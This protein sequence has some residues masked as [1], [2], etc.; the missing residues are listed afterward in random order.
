[1]IFLNSGRVC[2]SGVWRIGHRTIRA[3]HRGIVVIITIAGNKRGFIVAYF[4]L[5][6]QIISHFTKLARIFIE[7]SVKQYKGIGREFAFSTF[8]IDF[9]LVVVFLAFAVN[10]FKTSRLPFSSTAITRLTITRTDRRG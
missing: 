9:Y 10:I 7:Q 8:A 3:L 2:I 1:M 5:P 6:A 4:V